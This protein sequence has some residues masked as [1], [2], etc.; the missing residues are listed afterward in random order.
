MTCTD[1]QQP[2]VFLSNSSHRYVPTYRYLFNSTF[3]NQR[4]TDLPDDRWPVPTQQVY[5]SSE[6]PI[7]F[8]T[9]NLTN[10]TT[11]QIQLSNVMRHTWA[12]FARNPW[13]SPLKGWKTSGVNGS[14]VMEFGTDGKGKYELVK[15][16]TG[17]CWAWKDFIWRKH[18]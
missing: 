10:A 6:I 5:H 1:V 15:D 18:Y 12:N 2:A 14:T 16:V 3:P 8:S 9:Y 17:K 4:F 7:V 11:P 13:K